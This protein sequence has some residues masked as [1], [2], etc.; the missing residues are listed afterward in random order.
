MSKTIRVEKPTRRNL[1]HLHAKM[2]TGAGLHGDGRRPCTGPSASEWDWQDDGE[3][4]AFE[5]AFTPDPDA[6]EYFRT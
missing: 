6:A 2:R 1:V 5:P 4:E 3:G